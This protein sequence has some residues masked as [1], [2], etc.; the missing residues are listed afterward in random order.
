MC[1]KMFLMLKLAQ[2]GRISWMHCTLPLYKYLFIYIKKYMYRFW[3]VPGHTV[4]KRVIEVAVMK[5]KVVI[6]DQVKVIVTKNRSKMF[7]FHGN[8]G[9]HIQWPNLVHRNLL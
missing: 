7:P 8:F 2:N 6:G 9:M 5:T 3:S 4:T 1:F